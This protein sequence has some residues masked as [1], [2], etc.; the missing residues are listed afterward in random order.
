MSSQEP[1]RLTHISERTTEI[2]SS[3]VS[4]NS[5]T[6]QTESLIS[7]KI[8]TALKLKILTLDNIQ[9]NTIDYRFY[10]PEL[11]SIHAVNSKITGFSD[12]E[13]FFKTVGDKLK[14]INMS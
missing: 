9:I 3:H 8:E 14:K 13:E 6:K 12:A 7:R 1:H 4:T 11:R 10:I 2:S 5:V